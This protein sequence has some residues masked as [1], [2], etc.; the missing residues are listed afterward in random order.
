MSQ[1]LCA[2]QSADFRILVQPD[3]VDRIDSRNVRCSVVFGYISHLPIERWGATNTREAIS[4]VLLLEIVTYQRRDEE[5]MENGD[6]YYY[7]SP[8]SSNQNFASEIAQNVII[9]T[10]FVDVIVNISQ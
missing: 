3:F 6:I 7:R 4:L 5:N 2:D 8:I 1:R 9:Y 10:V